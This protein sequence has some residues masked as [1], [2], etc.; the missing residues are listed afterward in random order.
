MKKKF[1]IF[2][3]LIL[4]TSSVDSVAKS[5]TERDYNERRLLG[6]FD[7][8]K[9]VP[10]D[11]EKYDHYYQFMILFGKYQLIDHAHQRVN[12]LPD[13]LKIYS[14]Q[15]LAELYR[16]LYVSNGLLV[17]LEYLKKIDEN[18]LKTYLIEQLVF[19]SIQLSKL[20]DAIKFNEFVSEELIHERL[21]VILIDYLMKNNQIEKAEGFAKDLNFLVQ[22]DL[23]N[24]VLANGY[25]LNR[26]LDRMKNALRNIQNKKIKDE[27]TLNVIE[28]LIEKRMFT[29]AFEM[30]KVLENEQQID[31]SSF[32]LVKQY[33]EDGYIDSALQMLDSISNEVYKNKALSLVAIYSAQKG[34]T[35][36]TQSSIDK[37]SDAF[38]LEE[39]IIECAIEYARNDLYK[40]SIRLSL[41]I[42]TPSLKKD[43]NTSLAYVFAKGKNVPFAVLSVQQLSTDDF[44]DLYIQLAYGYIDF[45]QEEK[46]KKLLNL[47]SEESIQEDIAYNAMLYAAAE[48]KEIN[49][50][51][52]YSFLK[53]IY[54][55][56]DVAYSITPV[57]IDNQCSFGCEFVSTVVK[58]I[59]FKNKKSLENSK[60]KYVK[61]LFDQNNNKK[62]LDVEWHD[63]VKVL[64]K[65]KDGSSEISNLKVNVFRSLIK[66]EEYP[67]AFEILE[68]I[69]SLNRKIELLMDI[70]FVEDKKYQKKVYK[71][72]KNFTKKTK[73]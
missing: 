24:S 51:H 30:I 23:A 27:T 68:S 13:Q 32:W 72:F 67:L 3:F 7:L 12:T 8:V 22:K 55:K 20:D 25:A 63:L 61:L 53:S 71:L 49:L 48:N 5:Q 36:L 34:R 1:L 37:I 10:D 18:N 9:N 52:M 39:T 65:S 50:Q 2:S 21:I 54:Y 35:E 31:K 73:Q 15:L 26:Q 6:A 44:T 4:L 28:T 64:K 62:G 69:P 40:E 58:K 46:L 11:Q 66:L 43:V 57:L 33:I 45:D 42:K 16:S 41:D 60:I 47:I 17:T 19:E 38:I 29:N 14:R 59:K 56:V 70:P